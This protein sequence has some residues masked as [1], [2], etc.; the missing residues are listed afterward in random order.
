MPPHILMLAVVGAGLIA[1]YRMAHRA[2]KK[3]PPGAKTEAASNEPRDLGALEWDEAA[4][5]YRP[6]HQ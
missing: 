1:G 6:R 2:L 3:P 5:A 4:G